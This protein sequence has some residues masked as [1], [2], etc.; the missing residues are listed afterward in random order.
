MKIEREKV[1][2]SSAAGHRNSRQYWPGRDEDEDVDYEAL[3]RSFMERLFANRG[4]FKVD[5][6]LLFEFL[7]KAYVKNEQLISAETAFCFHQF[8]ERRQFGVV[9]NKNDNTPEFDEYKNS[10]MDSYLYHKQIV[11]PPMNNMDEFIPMI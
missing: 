11:P 9:V 2:G 1:L 3:F 7:P 4:A 8:E 6:S 5:G 10:A